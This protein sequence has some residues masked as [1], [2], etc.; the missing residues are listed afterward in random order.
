LQT[1]FIVLLNSGMCLGLFLPALPVAI[2]SE[3]VSTS[4]FNVNF[5]LLLTLAVGTLEGFNL[6]MFGWPV[7]EWPHSKNKGQIPLS[8]IPYPL[9]IRNTVRTQP[10][11]RHHQL[12][13]ICS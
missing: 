2:L 7:M 9:G 4:F 13:A 10:S 3:L 11:F 1:V 12:S 8:G 5:A 6:R